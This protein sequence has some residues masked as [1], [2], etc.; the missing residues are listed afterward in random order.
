MVEKEN[1]KKVNELRKH[2]NILERHKRG[3]WERRKFLYWRSKKSGEKGLT[4]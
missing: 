3:K 1:G 4:M 2:I